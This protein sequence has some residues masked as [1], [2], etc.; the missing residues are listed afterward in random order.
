MKTVK[1]ASFYLLVGFYLFMGII[2]FIQPELYLDMMP[3]WLPAHKFL[4]YL[5]G[6]AEIALAVLLIPIRTRATAAKLIIAMLLVFFFVV[7]I[8][9]SIKFYQTSD[10]KFLASIIRLPIQ[11]LFIAWAGMFAKK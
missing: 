7:H 9:E 2:H 11:F 1:K 8:P 4:I 6:F 5:S 3:A 10:G